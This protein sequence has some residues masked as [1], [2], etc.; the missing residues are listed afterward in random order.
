ME[1]DSYTISL[2]NGTIKSHD[3]FV[4][5]GTGETKRRQYQLDLIEP[6]KDWLGDMDMVWTVSDTAAH[7]VP[8]AHRQELLECAETGECELRDSCCCSEADALDRRRARLQYGRSVPFRVVCRLSNVFTVLSSP[9][10][11]WS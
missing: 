3:R 7:V 9:R 4:D 6:V 8:W 2:K 11:V 5:K 1:P 10:T